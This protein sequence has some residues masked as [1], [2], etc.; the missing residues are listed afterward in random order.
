MMNKTI[1]IATDID[2]RPSGQLPTAPAGLLRTVASGPQRAAAGRAGKFAQRG[3]SFRLSS[4]APFCPG[5]AFDTLRLS[6]KIL[7]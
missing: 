3:L 4:A 6:F 7:K 1:N 5:G 2:T